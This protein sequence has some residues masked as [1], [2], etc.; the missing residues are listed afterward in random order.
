MSTYFLIYKPLLV[1]SIYIKNL[2]SKSLSSKC[3]Q[4]LFILFFTILFLNYS[5]R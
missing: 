3:S 2:F 4:L 5:E 1:L